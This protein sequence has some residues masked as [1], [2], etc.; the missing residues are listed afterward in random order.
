MRFL[1]DSHALIWWW[2]GSP[3]LSDTVRAVLSDRGNTVHVSAATAWEIATKVR[4][5]KLPSMVER[6]TIFDQSVVQDGFVHLDVRHEHGV[7]GGLLEGDHRDP[8]D[9]IIAAQAIV[10]DLIL[11]TRD[12]EIAAFG[13][14]VLW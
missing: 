12:R 9:R 11:L 5:D 6:I 2:D 8:F 3:K 13:C 4:A 1:V 10:D 14:E 7:V